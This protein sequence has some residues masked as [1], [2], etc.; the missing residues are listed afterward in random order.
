VLADQTSRTAE[1]PAAAGVET[2]Q[3]LL[4]INGLAKSFGNGAERQSVLWE[5]GFDLRAGETLG[6]VGESE[7]AELLKG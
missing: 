3:T 2:R 7:S 5:V 6:R 1:P 4:H